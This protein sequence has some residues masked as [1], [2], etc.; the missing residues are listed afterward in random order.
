VTLTLPSTM[1]GH[2][3]TEGSGL[4]TVNTATRNT[5]TRNTASQN[6][7]PSALTAGLATL[8]GLKRAEKKTN[9]ALL[10]QNQPPRQA[11]C[12]RLSARQTGLKKSPFADEMQFMWRSH[13]PTYRSTANEFHQ[14]GVGAENSSVSSRTGC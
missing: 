4:A 8:L 2:A 9:F 3:A 6:T 12:T 10:L 5:L 14:D 7:K 13:R 1:S 11:N